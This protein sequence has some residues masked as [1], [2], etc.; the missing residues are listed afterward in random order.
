MES[1]KQGNT[2]ER[3]SYAL[4]TSVPFLCSAWFSNL[5]ATHSWPLEDAAAALG[6]SSNI[7]DNTSVG[8]AIAVGISMFI[9]LTLLRCYLAQRKARKAEERELGSRDDS[10]AALSNEPRLKSD[11]SENV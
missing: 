6:T 8:I 10:N 9:A 5:S 11:S 7:A 4:V 2:V 1:Q 3:V